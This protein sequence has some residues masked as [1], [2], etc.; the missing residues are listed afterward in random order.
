MEPEV[1]DLWQEY[2]PTGRATYTHSIYEVKQV[3]PH[4]LLSLWSGPGEISKLVT[5]RRLG[6]C[7]RRFRSARFTTLAGEDVTNGV[8]SS[9][10]PGSC[11]SGTSA[12]T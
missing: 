2:P 3:E 1:G 9:A 12:K 10:E 8:T 5:R 7:F 11:A 4:V 6:E